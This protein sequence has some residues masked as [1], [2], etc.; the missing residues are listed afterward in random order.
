MNGLPTFTKWGLTR[1][2]FLG[3]VMGG[4]GLA[5]LF[6]WIRR[7]ASE[8]RFPEPPG[9]DRS[10]NHRLG[11]LLRTGALLTRALDRHSEI[12]LVIVGG[13]IA[14]LSAGWWLQKNGFDQFKIIELENEVG[15]NSKSTENSVSAHPWGAHYVPIPNPE[16]DYVRMLF[17]EL[18]VI[19]GQDSSGR[20]RFNELYLCSD[21]SERIYYQGRWHEGLIPVDSLSPE[22][23]TETRRFLDLMNRWK[24]QIGSDGKR[25]FAIP[26]EQSSQDLVFRKLDQVSFRAWLDREGFKSS[27]LRW[28][29]DYCCR[30]DY[31][32]G[33]EHLSAWAGIHYFAGRKASSA[34]SDSS[35]VLTW[36]SGNGWIVDRL[37]EKLK[38]HLSPHQMAYRIANQ[39]SR[40][41][42]DVYHAEPGSDPHT[43]R[44]SAYH[45]IVATPRFAA[46]RMIPEWPSSQPLPTYAPW[47]VA[48]VTLNQMPSGKGVPLAWDNVS[49][50]SRSLGYIV[51]THQNLHPFP[52]KTVI[53]YYRPLDDES[54][55]IARQ[56]AYETS[57]AEWKSLV[58]S[59]L[60]KM[61]REIVP[62][63]LAIDICIWG[64][65]MVSPEP[66]FIWGEARKALL[67]PLGNI[68]FAHSDMSG[69]SIFEE[70]Q[71]RG[72]MAAREILKTLPASVRPT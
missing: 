21:P 29:V 68:H 2:R 25:A 51:A 12:P 48:N 23:R 57:L 32:R 42:I 41:E 11:H 60:Q 50:Y 64:H 18:G 71:Y 55:A 16:S 20:D 40:V 72:I 49:Y 56:K 44:I 36:P 10:P 69:I 26:M 1:R 66:G 54:P 22:S 38:G 30:D 33:P 28:Y 37:R 45:S 52:G 62:D 67:K 19:T 63:I 13:G 5:A 24:D 59:D 7:T 46:R 4:M 61:H 8:F 14:G 34:N 27:Y 9:Q 15:G 31:G 70:A 17:Q 47:L 53:T 65:G 58:Q 39:N 35:T 6:P 3:A 43:E